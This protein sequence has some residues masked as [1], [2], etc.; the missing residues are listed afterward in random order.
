MNSVEINVYSVLSDEGVG[1]CAPI[2]Q[3]LRPNYDQQELIQQIKHQ[4]QSGYKLLA[5]GPDESHILGVAGFRIGENLAWGKHI[6]IDD[7]VVDETCHSK[8]IGQLLLDFIIQFAQSK[9]IAQIH[10]DSGVQ[11]FSA[12]KFYLRSGFIISSHH[13]VKSQV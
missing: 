11:R 3:Q 5:A 4:L 2:M 13:F 7:L 12:H 9:E 8:G 10:L 6:Y 1:N